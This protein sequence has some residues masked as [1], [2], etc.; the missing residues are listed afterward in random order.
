MLSEI[1]IYTGTLVYQKIE[2]SFIFN[3][4][5][6]RLIPSKN[7]AYDV[8]KNFM[9]S[10]KNDNSLF[11]EE[12]YLIG[13]C[14]ETGKKI[15]FLITNSN[16]SRYNAV[17]VINIEAYMIQ[18]YNKEWIN[19]LG[20]MSQELDCIYPTNLA[21]QISD[22]R[23]DGIIS[24]KTKHFDSS[25]TYKQFFCVDNKDI[26]VYF[27][28]SRIRSNQINKPP[29]ELHSKMY[30]EFE[31]TKDYTFILKLY[32][33]AKYFIQFLCYRKNINLSTIEVATRIN[34]EN[35]EQFATLYIRNENRNNEPETLVMKRYIKQKYINGIEGKILNDIA[36]NK[37]YLE[38]IPETYKNGRIID[39][40]RFVMITAAFEWT[41]NKNYPNGVNK[42]PVSIEA[43]KNA[44][45]T[46]NELINNSTG[47]LKEIYKFLI[48]LIGSNSLQAK[49]E[50]M[51]KDYNDIIR[52]FGDHLYSMN[53]EVLSYSEMGLRISKQRNNFAHGNL[54]KDFIGLSLLDL[55]Y[56]EY[57]IYAMQLK[58]YGVDKLLIQ[59][60][61]NDL[62]GCALAI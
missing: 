49:I 31:N 34:S 46:L 61:I 11:I 8:C 47:K 20:F 22:Q 52:I 59:K 38:H 42:K 54:N 23:S 26:S 2:F 24:I 43:E 13:S 16:F 15:I 14:N 48:K 50:Q 27:G 62:F 4:K 39:A 44:S 7:I 58:E 33:I 60:A 30:F 25:T 56:L 10:S 21:L 3:K 12:N 57:V 1:E 28:I 9:I 29:L 18:K 41:F 53:N 36:T 45:A 40:A 51:G 5:E 32:F 17:I 6:L 19:R 35:Y 37:I 55:I